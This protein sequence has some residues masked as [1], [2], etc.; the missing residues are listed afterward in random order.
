MKT[1][2]VLAML[3]ALLIDTAAAHASVGFTMLRVAGWRQ[4]ATGGGGMVSD[5]GRAPSYAHR[6]V[7]PECG[8]GRGVGG[9]GLPLVVMSHGNGG[10]F[11]GHLDTASA[12]AEAGFVVAA[13]THT[14][15]ITATRAGRPISV[16]A[17]GR[18]PR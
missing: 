5:L 4:P 13:P 15:I 12:L 8:A 3:A 9:A 18:S 16:G 1:L 11:D 10:V 2:P 7:H 17:C 14:G 6:P